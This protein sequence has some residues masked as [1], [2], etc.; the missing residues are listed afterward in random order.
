M[1]ATK[2]DKLARKG[3]RHCVLCNQNVCSIKI[4]SSA[5][6]HLAINIDITRASVMQFATNRVF[7]RGPR[8]R[9]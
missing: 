4:P 5:H 3:T 8:L 7:H 6:R 9:G 2:S 1:A